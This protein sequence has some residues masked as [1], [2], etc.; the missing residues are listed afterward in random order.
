MGRR[1]LRRNGM[2]AN[3]PGTP[4]HGP[5]GRGRAGEFREGGEEVR[6]RRQEMGRR[7]FVRL[8]VAVPVVGR[9]AQLG[10]TRRST[11]QSGTSV[12]AA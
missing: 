10:A 1:T 4:G 2:H 9:A 11:G 12:E 8:P 3:P 5:R 6:E 7:R